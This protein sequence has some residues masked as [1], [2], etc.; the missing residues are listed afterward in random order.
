[1]KRKS[2]SN[3]LHQ[4]CPSCDGAG[5]VP[6]PVNYGAD[7]R[8]RRQ[9]KG[10][11]LAALAEKVEISAQYLCDLEL[12]RRPMFHPAAKDLIKRLEAVLAK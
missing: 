1:M 9:E 6:H 11:S 7:L 2:S 4:S 10:L 5:T 12:G 8:R 3:N